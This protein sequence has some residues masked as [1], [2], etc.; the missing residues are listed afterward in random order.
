MTERDLDERVPERLRDLP[1]GARALVV[2]GVPCLRQ[3]E[4]VGVEGTTG[5]H[6]VERPSPA[7]DTA[8]HVP[9]GDDEMV[10][11]RD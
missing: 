9:G 10:H 1:S 11:D 8:V 2:V 6:D 7:V 3:D 5:R 4:D